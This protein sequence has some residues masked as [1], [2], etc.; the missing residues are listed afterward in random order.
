LKKYIIILCILLS[1]CSTTRRNADTVYHPYNGIN[2][3]NIL[4]VNYSWHS[5]IIIKKLD[6]PAHLI[7]EKEDFSDVEFLEI[8]WGHKGFYQA[9]K[10]KLSLAAK[11]LF[12]PG[13]ST[14]AV[15]GFSGPPEVEYSDSKI[16]ALNLSPGQF[17]QVMEAID[18]SFDRKGQ[19]RAEATLKMTNGGGY[20]YDAYGSY[21]ML[22]T[23]NNWTAKVLH[24]G[25]VP[26]STSLYSATANNV[27]SQ[28]GRYGVVVRAENVQPIEP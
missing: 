17:Y 23:C 12:F 21:S 5:G 7:P 24:R 16:T 13:K 6:I 18:K 4:V 19:A 27:M 3:R 20:F 8:G 25:G 1:G 15:Y 22:R 2:T 9:P 14:M 10:F 11:A 28:V 26:I